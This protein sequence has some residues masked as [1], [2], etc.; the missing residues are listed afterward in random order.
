MT[1]VLDDG[2]GGAG[3]FHERTKVG[4]PARPRPPGLFR[5]GGP[6]TLT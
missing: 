5:E 1:A 2:D 6:R 4:T 3:A